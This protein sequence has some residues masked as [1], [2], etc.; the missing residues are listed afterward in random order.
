MIGTNVAR[1]N[2]NFLQVIKSYYQ[3][4]KPRIIPLLLI[5]TA[6]SMWIASGGQVEPVKLVAALAGG[7]LA[8]ASAQTLNCVYDRDID[9]SMLRTRHRPIPSGRV[10]PVHAVIFAA[11]LAALSFS[12]FLAFVNL[13]SGLLALS[14][15]IFYMLV[16]THWLKR[17]TAQNI[18]IGGAA[19]AIPPLVGWAAVTGDLSWTAWAIFGIIF[20]W[21]PPHFWA[22]ALMIKDDYAEVDVPMMPVVAGEESTAR[23]IWVYTAIVVPFTFV[24]VYPLGT[25][26]WIYGAIAAFL[27]IIFLLKARQLLADP[28]DKD[29]ARSLFKYSILYLMLLCTG[30]VVDSLP[31]TH[32][33]IAFASEHLRT[34]ASFFPVS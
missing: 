17:N 7:T 30:M 25:A 19:G 28:F 1:S 26:G 12:L 31:V 14:G 5:T 33:A 32:Q 15:I 27:G 2:E 4:T 3:L 9:Y 24:L 34:I 20:L 21:T 11:V 16:Y 23:Q 6:G 13:L 8:A 10:Q 18:V 29:L 22:L